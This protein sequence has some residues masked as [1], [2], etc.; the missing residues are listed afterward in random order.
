MVLNVATPLV[1]DFF[2]VIEEMRLWKVVRTP[3]QIR[4]SMRADDGRGPGVTT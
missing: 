4:E 2:G 1:Q 3:A